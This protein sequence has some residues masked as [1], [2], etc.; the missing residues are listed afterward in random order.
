MITPLPDNAN[1][2]IIIDASSIIAMAFERTIRLI[3]EPFSSKY[4]RYVTFYVTRKSISEIQEF[5]E[6]KGMPKNRIEE[7]LEYLRCYLTEIGDDDIKSFKSEAQERIGHRDPKDWQ[8]VALA[9]KLG[10]AILTE[11]RDFLGTGIPTWT[12]KTIKRGLGLII[13]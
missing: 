10:C 4:N 9:L 7:R 3:L 11:D 12:E 6:G 13:I 1:L 8:E 5:Y 2:P